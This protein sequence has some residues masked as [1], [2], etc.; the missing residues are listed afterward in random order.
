MN[1]QSLNDLSNSAA[2]PLPSE[3]NNL[4]HTLDIKDISSDET[5]SSAAETVFSLLSGKIRQRL[6][7]FGA[8]ADGHRS[9]VLFE[10]SNRGRTRDRQHDRRAVQ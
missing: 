2:N 5:G 3:A 10:M 6:D 4:L 1:M 7:L 8:R 9:E